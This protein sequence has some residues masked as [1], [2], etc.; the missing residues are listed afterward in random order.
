M[1]DCPQL[2]RKETMSLRPNLGLVIVIVVELLGLIVG[3]KP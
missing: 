3:E 2:V 1:I